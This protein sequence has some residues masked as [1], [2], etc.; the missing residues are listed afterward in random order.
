MTGKPILLF[1]IIIENAMNNQ[2]LFQNNIFPNS[3]RTN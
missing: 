1:I 3:K 2:E